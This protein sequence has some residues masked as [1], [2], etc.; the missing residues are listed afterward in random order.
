[1]PTQSNVSATHTHRLLS[2]AATVNPAV[3][4]ASRGTL[5][6]IQGTNAKAAVVYFKLYDKATTPAETDTP[7]KTISLPASAAFNL[8]FDDYFGAG[9]AYR[10]TAAAADNDTTALSAGDVLALN[11]DYR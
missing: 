3:V 10:M 7:R 4:K 6:R 11:V 9:I 2:A 8:E 5:R 1:M